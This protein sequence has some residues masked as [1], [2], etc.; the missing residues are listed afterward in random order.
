MK[1]ALQNMVKFLKK[2]AV[3]IAAGYFALQICMVALVYYWRVFFHYGGSAMKL[4]LLCFLVSTVLF[5][6]GCVTVWTV[7]S[8]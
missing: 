3:R 6:I 1:G 4:T 2:P 5:A 7:K 8:F